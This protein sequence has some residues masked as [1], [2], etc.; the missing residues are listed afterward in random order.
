MSFTNCSANLI[1]LLAPIAAGN[2]TEGKPT[3][4]QWRIVFFIAAGVYIF[5][6]TFYNIFSSGQRQP[7]DNP[8]NDK[9]NEEKLNQKKLSIT[10]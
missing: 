10:K 7:W 1:G 9:E 6:A 4:A 3:H 2:I 5:C 8:E